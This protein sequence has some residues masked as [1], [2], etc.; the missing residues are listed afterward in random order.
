MDSFLP[1]LE[2]PQSVASRSSTC[3]GRARPPT[4]PPPWSPSG[5]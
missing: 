2:V 4:R 1:A 5:D 3:Q